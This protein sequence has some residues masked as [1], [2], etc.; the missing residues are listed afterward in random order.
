MSYPPDPVTVSSFSSGSQHWQTLI[1]QDGILG[2]DGQPIAVATSVGKTANGEQLTAVF[3]TG[4]TLP[5]VP[6]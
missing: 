1:D 5:Q 4:F 2:P 6:K 3:D